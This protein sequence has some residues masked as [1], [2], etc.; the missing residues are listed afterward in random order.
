MVNTGHPTAN[1][2]IHL[3]MNAI[4]RGPRYKSG[5]PEKSPAATPPVPTAAEGILGG[6]MCAGRTM[7][8]GP[9]LAT[10]FQ[11]SPCFSWAGLPASDGTGERP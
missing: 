5:F 4:P 6:E 11:E 9:A 10:L 2:I 8:L 1:A 3:I 7:A